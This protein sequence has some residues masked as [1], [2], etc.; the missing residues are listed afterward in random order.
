[1]MSA[2]KRT[3]VE[4]EK[5]RTLRATMHT[6]EDVMGNALVSMKY[7]LM[8]VANNGGIDQETQFRLTRAIDDAMQQLHALGG[9][10]VVNEKQFAENIYYLERL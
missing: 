7:I 10:T 4:M 6:V 8:D 5:F 1:M 2:D 3:N 9:L